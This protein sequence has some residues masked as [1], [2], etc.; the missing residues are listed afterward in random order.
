MAG[1]KDDLLARMEPDLNR[2]EAALQNN[3]T[4]HLQLVSDTAGHLIFSGGKRL[5]PLLNVLCARL[6]GYEDE[7]VVKFST[8]VEFLHTATLL[9]DDVVD[10]AAMRRGKPVAHAVFGAPVTVLVGDFLLARALSIAAQTENPKI[11]RIISDI[12]ESMCQGEIQQLTRKGDIRLTES[13]YMEVIQRKTGFLIQGACQTGAILAGA[14]AEAEKQLSEYGYHIGIVFQIADDLLDYIAETD[15][16]GKTV[17]ADLREGKL[18]LPLIHVLARANG[19]DRAQ[20]VEIV[21]KKSFSDDEF[22]QLVKI[23]DS[24]GGISYSRDIAG[25]HVERAKAILAAFPP[26]ETRETLSMLADYALSRGS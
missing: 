12:T 15:T 17:G 3:L 8:I 23:I 2:I 19:K 21:Q 1:L 16:L 18:T 4:P 9:H 22:N 6:C 26:S 14:D 7:F 11:I 5:R 20:V 10:D 24:Y 13:E 25:T